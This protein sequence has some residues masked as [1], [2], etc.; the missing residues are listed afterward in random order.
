[1][2][3]IEVKG[4]CSSCTLLKDNIVKNI[5]NSGKRCRDCINKHQRE[6]RK[7]TN[8]KNTIKYEK[9]LKGFIMRMYRNMKS[10]VGGVQ[11]A[12]FHLYEGKELLSKDEFYHWILNNK[13]FIK[14]FREYELS[15]YEM[16]LAPT[17]DRIDSSNGYILSNM[18][19]ITHSEN[20]RRGSMSKNSNNTIAQ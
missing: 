6:Y 19:I 20:S 8:N 5:N 18:E 1:M 12:K 10:R 15:N 11:K 2:A 7:V 4:E 9:T 14:L 16:K 3:S 13:E 17:V